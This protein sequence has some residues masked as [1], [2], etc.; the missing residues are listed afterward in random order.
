MFITG[1]FGMN[2]DLISK[3]PAN[4]KWYWAIVLSLITTAVIVIVWLTFKYSSIELVIERSTRTIAKRAREALHR[5]DKEEERVNYGE[6]VSDSGSMTWV[7][8]WVRT[9]TGFPVDLEKGGMKV[10]VKVD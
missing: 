6:S 9:Q 2:I 5:R 10:G 4:P 7:P 3:D 1:I 8:K